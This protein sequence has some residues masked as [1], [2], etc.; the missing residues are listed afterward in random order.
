MYDVGGTGSQ[1]ALRWAM[2]HQEFD[3]GSPFLRI[4]DSIEEEGRWA[5]LWQDRFVIGW[6]APARQQGSQGLNMKQP[7]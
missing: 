1:D 6:F 7:Y 2:I 3:F 5:A 4:L